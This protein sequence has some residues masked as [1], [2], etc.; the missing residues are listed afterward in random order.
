MKHFILEHWAE[1][2]LA[3]FAFVKVTLELTSKTRD[4]RVFAIFDEFLES[5]IPNQLKRHNRRKP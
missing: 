1:V 2:L 5:L 3:S 4:P